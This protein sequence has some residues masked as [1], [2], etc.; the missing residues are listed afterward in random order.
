MKN[1]YT[2]YLTVPLKEYKK[3]E[4]KMESFLSLF[5]LITAIFVG[6]HPTQSDNK[7]NIT[8]LQLK[9]SLNQYQGKKVIF[10]VVDS[11]MANRIENC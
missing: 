7:E 8:K 4:N 11:L 1:N 5:L 6:W 3:H 9:N 2:G 10:F